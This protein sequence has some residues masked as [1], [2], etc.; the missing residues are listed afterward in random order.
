M[1]KV[2]QI[3]IAPRGNVHP[4]VH[5]HPGVNTLYCLEKWR[6][7]RGSSPPVDN[8]TPGGRGFTSLRKIAQNVAQ[9]IFCQ[10]KYIIY[11]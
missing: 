6:M 9:L 4:S 5:P 10:N 2:L 1:L 3:S 7:N 8:F 11:T